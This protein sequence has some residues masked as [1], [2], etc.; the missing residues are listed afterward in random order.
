MRLLAFSD[1]HRDRAA[2]RR[3]VARSGDADVVIGAGDFASMRIGLRSALDA[4]AAIAKPVLLVP[5]NNESD[6]ALWRAA[7]ALPDARV[8]HGDGTSVD[9]V[10]FYGVGAGV[11]PTPFPWSWDLSEPAAA[12]LLSGCPEGAVLIVHSPPFGHVDT[13]FGRHLG[14]RSILDAIRAK[15]PPLV[16]CGHI[17]QC[18]GQEAMIGRSRV[19]NVGPE[20][21]LFDL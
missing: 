19:V 8:L 5:G 21:R 3:L 4:L 1:L 20:G 15:R 7:A 10:W 13:A 12:E 6:S 17:H 18:W 16:V 9:G 2:A 14:S 11:P